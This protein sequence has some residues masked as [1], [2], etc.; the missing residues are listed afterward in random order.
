MTLQLDK[1]LD[2]GRDTDRMTQADKSR[3]E[4]TVDSLLRAF[5]DIPKRR[6]EVQLLADEVG[7]GKTFVA[8]ATAYG[9]LDATRNGQEVA[10][11][12]GL[13][14]C[15]RAA[16]VVVP[17][18]NHALANKW[19]QEVE[20]LRTRCSTDMKQTDWFH[21]R[22]CENAYE[23]AEG[24]Q[25]ASDLRRDPRKNPCVLICAANVFRRRVGDLDERLRFLAA[26]LFRWWGN[27]LTQHERYRIVSR[28]AD[29]RGFA[30][31]AESAS[32]VSKGIFKVDLWDFR[33]HEKYLDPFQ[34][35]KWDWSTELVR[36]YESAQFAYED[37][38]ESLE[39]LEKSNDGNEL[40]YSEAERTREGVQ[41]PAGL[42]PFCKNAAE[43]RG[44]ADWYFEGFKRRLLSLYK[45]L[46]PHLIHRDLPLV[47][48]DEAHHWRH[49]H[50]QDCQDFRS[51]L[52]PTC[53]RLLL[54]T[55]TPFQLHRDELLEVLSVGD[56]MSPAIGED[57]VSILQAQRER[58]RKAMESSEI[59][60]K[61]FAREWGALTDQFAKLDAR[62]D[63]AQ[64][65]LP[66]AKDPRTSEL[67]RCWDELDLSNTSAPSLESSSIPG[68]LR[69]FF[70]RAIE[71]KASNELL[72]TSMR[73]L[74]IRHRRG[75]K[76]RRVWI[77]SEYPPKS[78]VSL[79]PDQHLLHLAPGAVVPPHAEL[80]QYLLMKVVAEASR[81]KHRTTLGM[82][83]TGCYSTLW[84][85]KEGAKATEA[86]MNSGSQPLLKLLHQVTGYRSK[87]VN[88]EDSR[89]P[90]VQLV[91]EEV[92]NRWQNG[93]KSLIFC[94]RVP[95]AETL[96]KLLALGVSQRLK[97]SRKL[98]LESR[99]TVLSDNLD[100]DK[101]MQQFRRSLTA[102]EGNGISLF[103]DRVLLGWLKLHEYPLPVLTDD[104]RV[105]ISHLYSRARHQGSPLVRQGERIRP[106][107][108]FLNRAMEHVLAKRLLVERDWMLGKNSELATKTQW[109][110]EQ[111][112]DESWIAFR[113]GQEELTRR[114]SAI[115]ADIT[116]ADT[117]A[118]SSMSANYYLDQIP[119]P[120]FVDLVIKALR[121]GSLEENNVSGPN[122]L[123]PLG[124][125]T[126]DSFDDNAKKRIHEMLRLLFSISFADGKWQWDERAKVLDA[127]VRALLREDILLRL[128]VGVFKNDEE[129]WAASILRGL[130]EPAGKGQ[131][132]PLAGRVEEFLRELA[133]MGPMERESHLRFAMNPK[134]EAVVLVTGS[135][136]VDRDAVFNGF[137][138]PLLPD[139][140]VCT[141]VGQEGIDLHRHCRHV[142]H[143]DLGWN[144][145]TLEQRT[146]RTDRIGSKALRERRLAEESLKRNGQLPNESDLAGLD[147]ALPYLAG[148]YDERMFDRL[149]GR[150]QTFEIL[151][152]GDATA[153]REDEASW[154]DPDDVGRSEGHE[155]V[156]LPI[157]MLE[158][159]RVDLSADRS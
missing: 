57:R 108:V 32:R 85:S 158:H 54:L 60:G 73:H 80:S 16:I 134:A 12:I 47:I 147:I 45:E 20:A 51:H 44:Y 46:A 22:V 56:A 49:S 88:R 135:S 122:L 154:L 151:T 41:E 91:V 52:A 96:A 65:W 9:I 84:Q 97:K 102:R 31:W 74:I 98:L 17:S 146:G 93:E 23:L 76:H 133:E 34:R 63:P 95:T 33:E 26:C 138:T 153:D 127:V 62:F 119:D 157:Q 3:Q 131:L 6:C 129:T 115:N 139:I 90:K 43:K 77:G 150:S 36:R 107:R 117:V 5:T 13:S 106:D 87:G 152:G 104:D 94:F 103:L 14:K 113:Y 58:I 155:Y 29:V 25:R 68:L 86:A 61:N 105:A 59:A 124:K 118:R 70:A 28:A 83:L 145:A 143:Y 120:S 89:H 64:G 15:Y 148:T 132:E 72:R 112:A 11:S 114:N 39:K 100:E 53:R 141:Q 128:P 110:L 1:V 149:R 140:L 18:G 21:S 27:K 156:P 50:R 137:N 55:A 4:A 116:A 66:G 69:P 7:L 125:D 136:N 126:L 71:L 159:L 24:L 142:V 2:L 67:E 130:H 37:I 42:L 75:V 109:L 82:D 123:V 35:E 111:L 92:L 30:S 48:V 81:G 19:H 101:A 144:P 38:V 78:D 99:G 79:R 121:S 10:E 40:L 8:L